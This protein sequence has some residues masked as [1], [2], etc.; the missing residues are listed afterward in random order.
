MKS[1]KGLFIIAVLG[2]TSVS[3]ANTVTITLGLMSFTPDT[4][5]VTIGDTVKWQW[6]TGIHTTTSTIIPPGAPVWN[7]PMDAADQT[8]LYAV[9][10]A[11]VYHY[12][13]NIHALMGMVGVF[14]VNPI[15]ITPI[16]AIVPSAYSLYQNY[17][18]PFNPST[19]INFDVPEKSFVKMSIYDITGVLVTTLVNEELKQGKYKVDWD[20][21]NFS[22][23]VYFITFSSQKGF[24]KT[25]R[26]VLL[27]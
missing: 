16:S 24:A 12:Q 25:I 6:T 20:G 14:I 11:G 23:G 5:N 4:V 17:P 26:M 1:I 8:F 19:T 15:G 27:K 18:N 21:A 9:T 2:L 10:V 22:S 3:Q 13:C 7:A